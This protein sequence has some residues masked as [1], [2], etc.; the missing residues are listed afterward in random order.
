MKKILMIAVLCFLSC[1][2]NKEPIPVTLIKMVD[3]FKGKTFVY[4]SSSAVF[5]TIRMQNNTIKDSISSIGITSAELKTYTLKS[6]EKSSLVTSEI[7]IGVSKENDSS[8]YFDVW[9][10]NASLGINSKDLE[11]KVFKEKGYCINRDKLPYVPILWFVFT[12]EK[13]IT[14]YEDCDGV[15]WE[16]VETF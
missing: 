8:V 12:L 1:E 4:K 9:F 2:R 10:K 3:S 5:D 11:S 13:G 16:L 6:A 15:T 14:S 7:E